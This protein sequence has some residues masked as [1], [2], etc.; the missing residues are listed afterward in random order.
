MNSPVPYLNCLANRIY[1][2]FMTM[3]HENVVKE[4]IRCTKLAHKERIILY[5]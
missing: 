2:Y 4:E 3:W 1:S 5:Q